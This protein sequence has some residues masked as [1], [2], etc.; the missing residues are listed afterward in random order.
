MIELIDVSKKYGEQEVLK[1]ITYSFEKGKV[2]FIVGESGCG[3]TTLLKLLSGEDKD[4][5]GIILFNKEDI[6]EFS[7]QENY[8]YKTTGVSYISQFPVT[9][10]EVKAKTNIRIP[11]FVNKK[12]TDIIGSFLKNIK[13]NKKAKSLSVGERQRVC[14]QRC[15]NQNAHVVLAD[16]PTASLDNESKNEVI[17]ELINR[18]IDKVLIIVTHD[19]ELASKY[20]DEI[21][22]IKKSRIKNKKRKKECQKIIIDKASKSISLKDSFNFAKEIYKS[23]SRKTSLYNYSLVIGIVLLTFTNAL[24]DGMMRYFQ[25]Q[26]ITQDYSNYIEYEYEFEKIDDDDLNNI[27]NFVGENNIDFIYSNEKV[28]TKIIIEEKEISIPNHG[29]INYE[30]NEK[31]LNGVIHISL[32]EE[33]NAYMTNQMRLDKIGIDFVCYVKDFV[34][35][36]EVRY[37]NDEKCVF[38][39]AIIGKIRIDN[40][41]FLTFS[42]SDEE[43]IDKLKNNFDLGYQM[44]FSKGINEELKEFLNNNEEYFYKENNLYRYI[45]GKLDASN[46]IKE[47]KT[48][49]GNVD[50]TFEKLKIEGYE[51][52]V[53]FEYNN[54]HP[55]TGRNAYKENELVLS[56]ALEND[57]FNE[58]QGIGR[59]IKLNHKGVTKSFVVVGIIKNEEKKIYY[60]QIAFES[61]LNE[62]NSFKNYKKFPVKET[63]FLKENIDYNELLSWAEKQDDKYSSTLIEVLKGML[64]T[65]NGIKFIMRIFSIFS[66]VI[67]IV[68]LFVLNILDFESKKK[69]Y[70]MLYRT[71]FKNI[72]ILKINGFKFLFSSISI[73]ITSVLMIVLMKGA[74]NKI[75]SQNIGINSLFSNVN[76][77]EILIYTGSYFLISNINFY[78]Y[79]NVVAKRMK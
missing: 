77:N 15:I 30:Y 66:L 78:L 17:E 13:T 69:E 32:S 64:P 74:L 39:N 40:S 58:N 50:F 5:E 26:L 47:R 45:G 38:F 31:V 44:D 56:S 4:Y 49:Y 19:I 46:L 35:E 79:L 52:T 25:K 21:L 70:S 24:S 57:I 10:Q 43:L 9:F 22:E 48:E 42:C 1:N 59:Q 62:F 6:K 63:L 75:I 65:M 73:A 41:C 54:K 72:D 27:I 51:E 3:K 28:E 60:N 33:A 8:D 34:P 23:E 36:I 53:L 71:G 18:S 7:K 16:E 12:T 67:S 76:L 20:A 61:L 2:Y 68:T 14:I 29:L 55:S 11:K 37:Q